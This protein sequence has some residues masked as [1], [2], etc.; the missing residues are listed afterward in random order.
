MA[1]LRCQEY[2]S[3]R[4]LAKCHSLKKEMI[5]QTPSHVRM[6]PNISFGCPLFLK[7]NCRKCWNICEAKKRWII[8][9]FYKCLII[10]WVF[11]YHKNF[12]KNDNTFLNEAY[13]SKR[14][15]R[16]LKH[17]Q[18]IIVKCICNLDHKKDG[19]LN[20]TAFW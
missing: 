8:S 10:K 2:C 7:T 14:Y 16:M 17:Q 12:Y 5:R 20:R 19:F 13:S 6:N 11:A 18:P 9:E 1:S 4:H 3:I 15:M